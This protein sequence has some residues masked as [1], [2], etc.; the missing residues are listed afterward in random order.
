MDA[1]GSWEKGWSRT[2]VSRAQA[3]SHRSHPRTPRPHSPP[4]DPGAAPR[5]HPRR[6]ARG[7]ERGLQDRPA[8]RARRGQASRD[9]SAASARGVRRCPGDRFSWRNPTVLEVFPCKAHLSPPKHPGWRRPALILSQRFTPRWKV[10]VRARVTGA[11]PVRL[12]PRLGFSKGRTRRKKCER[13]SAG[14][15]PPLC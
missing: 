10:F 4:G 15:R 7:K 13:G 3:R 11:E 14:A 2:S 12:Q 9:A 6:S 8:L 5:L 1:G